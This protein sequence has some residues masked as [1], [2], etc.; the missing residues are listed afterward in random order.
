MEMVGIAVGREFDRF[1]CVKGRALHLRGF[2]C[3]LKIQKVLSSA[4]C[5]MHPLFWYVNHAC[6]FM[7][8]QNHKEADLSFNVEFLITFVCKCFEKQTEINQIQTKQ[9][10]KI[11][12]STCTIW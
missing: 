2:P 5:K 4:N 11:Y 10:M 9:L 7:F 6:F 12:T 8:T 3:N 1:V